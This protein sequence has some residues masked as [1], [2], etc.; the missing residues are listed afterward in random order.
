ME[1]LVPFVI[2]KYRMLPQ[3]HALDT[4]DQ[5]VM[6]LFELNRGTYLSQH[7]IYQPNPPRCLAELI[8]LW[9]IIGLLSMVS[10]QAHINLMETPA[11]VQVT[12]REDTPP[13]SSQLS[14]RPPL[15]PPTGPPPSTKVVPPAIKKM[16]KV[17]SYSTAS[18][19][20]PHPS[21]ETSAPLAPLM[22]LRVSHW[23]NQS[24]QLAAS[25]SGATAHLST[26]APPQRPV[27]W[28]LP[29]V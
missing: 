19:T 23:H 29:R 18:A 6:K 26:T 1:D 24:S 15:L 12:S 13:P 27:S 5:E 9:I 3:S 16:L 25:S 21:T 17:T 10:P 20:L 2:Q 4:Q 22:S 28:S 14:T 7:R 11:G 8:Q